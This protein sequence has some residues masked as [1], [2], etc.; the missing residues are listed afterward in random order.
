MLPALLCPPALYQT[1]TCRDDGA[2]AIGALFLRVIVPSTGGG[3]GRRTDRLC[4]GFD[5]LQIPETSTG[6]RPPVLFI[7]ENAGGG[8][9]FI[10]GGAGRACMNDLVVAQEASGVGVG[11]QFVRIVA[12]SM[13]NT[14]NDL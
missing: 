2:P 4:D 14:F 5:A 6:R 12:V 3:A 7:Q 1:H 11:V 13:L 10:G 8:D 9:Y